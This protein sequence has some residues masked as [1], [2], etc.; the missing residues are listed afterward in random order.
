MSS[1]SSNFYS[2]YNWVLIGK[3]FSWLKFINICE[4]DSYFFFMIFTDPN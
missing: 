3:S 1:D 4:N 2:I